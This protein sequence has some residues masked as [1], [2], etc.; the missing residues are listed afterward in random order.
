MKLETSGCEVS[1]ILTS[2]GGRGFEVHLVGLISCASEMND[3]FGLD[4]IIEC[5][6]ITCCRPLEPNSKCEIDLIDHNMAVDMPW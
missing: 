3:G 4:R 1:G 6:A 2:A 5:P